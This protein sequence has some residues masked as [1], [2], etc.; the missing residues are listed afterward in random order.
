MAACSL[1]EPC[2]YESPAMMIHPGAGRDDM[3]GRDLIADLD[4]HFTFNR[5]GKR[6]IYRRNF[7][8]RAPENFHCRGILSRLGRDD[9]TVIY[10][11]AIRHVHFR[12]CHAEVTGVGKSS[13]YC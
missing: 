2:P 1:D 6:V 7:Y 10:V 9:H 11:K 13:G 5:I 8:I 4:G 3:I 12:I